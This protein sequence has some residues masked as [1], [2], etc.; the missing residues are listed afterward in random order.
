MENIFDAKTVQNYIDRIQQLNANTKG[1]WGKMSVDQMLAHCNITYS[2]IFEP[3]KHKKPGMIASFLL[4]QFVKDKVVNEQPYKQSIPTG[5]AFLIH[6]ERQFEEEQKKLIGYLQK[7]QQ[8]GPSAFE[9]KVSLSFGK[10]SAK[11]WNNMM[12]KHLN[13]H[14]S[15]FGV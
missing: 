6:D 13:H 1:K 7:V 8:L 9:G 2:M 12:A 4:K 5:P 10:L 11:E 15:Q 14:L 3:E